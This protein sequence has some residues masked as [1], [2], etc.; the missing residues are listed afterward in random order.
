MLIFFFSVY[1]ELPKEKSIDEGEFLTVESKI[2]ISGLDLV[3]T[4]DRWGKLDVRK[5]GRRISRASECCFAPG[6]GLY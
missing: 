4:K 5:K 1:I 6:H 3:E 2:Q